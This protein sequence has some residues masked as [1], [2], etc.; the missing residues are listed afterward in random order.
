MEKRLNKI[1]IEIK[2]GDGRKFDEFYELTN[3]FVYFS[4]L[5][6][7]CDRASAEDVMH[8]VYVAI[9]RNIASYS[10]KNNALGYISTITKNMSLNYVK[11][12]GRAISV[13]FTES[14]NERLATESGDMSTP[15]LD[16]A[17]RVL[18]EE[19]YELVLL[20]VV[21]GYRQVEISKLRC[22]PVSTINFKIKSA[23]KKIKKEYEEN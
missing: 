6:I 10:D 9:I 13:D 11:K 23:L 7:V 16:I 1:L 12:N 20:N 8:D 17:A 2:N 22:E 15:L 14:A 19:E 5:K 4:A 18:T 21:S 3:K